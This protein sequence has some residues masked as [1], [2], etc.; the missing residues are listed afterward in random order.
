[1]KPSVSKI[2][3]R[4]I[5]PFIAFLLLFNFYLFFLDCI[6]V[7]QVG[8]AWNRI[9]GTMWLQEPGWYV[10]APWTQVARIDTRPMRVA[11]TTAG[12]GFSAK[13]VQFDRRGWREFVA[14]E[15]FHYYWWY[16]RIS[17]NLG[18]K[19]E[20]RGMRD[21]MRGYAYGVTKYPFVAIL[22]EY[23]N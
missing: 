13:L 10:T 21:V 16:N 23:Q 17:F 3:R 14:T 1:M 2:L 4:S 12:H 19:E 22:K 15:G 6:E 18:Y 5:G 9:N 11:V 8:I 7:A 20:Y